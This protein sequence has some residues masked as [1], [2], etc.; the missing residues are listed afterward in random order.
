VQ[1]QSRQ[2]AMFQQGSWCSFKP[3]SVYSRR[4]VLELSSSSSSKI[5]VESNCYVDY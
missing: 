5:T 1:K 4:N 2:H 3:S